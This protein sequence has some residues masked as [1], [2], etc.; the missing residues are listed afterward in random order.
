MIELRLLNELLETRKTVEPV[1]FLAVVRDR[2][3]ALI[4][5]MRLVTRLMVLLRA[6]LRVSTT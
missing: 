2:L 5:M 4:L 6:R 3:F 1:Y